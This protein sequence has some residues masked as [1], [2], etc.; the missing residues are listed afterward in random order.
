MVIFMAKRRVMDSDSEESPPPPSRGLTA[1]SLPFAR[2]EILPVYTVTLLDL[3]AE[4]VRAQ[5]NS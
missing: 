4:I 1:Y 5:T 3:P 2:A